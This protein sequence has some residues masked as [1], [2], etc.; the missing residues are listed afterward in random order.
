MLGGYKPHFDT[1]PYD[2]ACLYDNMHVYIVL[3]YIYIYTNIGL[4]QITLDHRTIVSTFV[5]VEAL[6]APRV[7]PEFLVRCWRPAPE[8]EPVESEPT[9]S[10]PVHLAKKDQ[11]NRRAKE[12]LAGWGKNGGGC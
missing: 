4:Y 2:Y 8:S 1:N 6:S 5:Q 7:R 9:L 3:L 11:V 10:L 12:Q